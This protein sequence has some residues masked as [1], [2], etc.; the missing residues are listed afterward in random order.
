MLD[1]HHRI[2][3][4]HQPLQL[5][6]Q[7]VRIR[8]MQAGGGFVQHVQRAPALAALQLGGQLDALGLAA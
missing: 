6:Q 3:C 7:P 5:H 2:S 8:R 1:H 4:V